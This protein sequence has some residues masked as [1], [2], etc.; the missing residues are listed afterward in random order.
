MS[1]TLHPKEKGQ[2]AEAIVMA[3]L[4]RRGITVLQPFGDN[5]RYDLVVDS[6]DDFHRI[7]VK[8]GRIDN[9]SIVFDIKSTGVNAHSTEHEPY[10]EDEIDFFAGYCFER[11]EVYIIPI[12]ETGSH[13]MSLRFEKADRNYPHINWVDDYT[14]STWIDTFRD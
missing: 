11:D 14:L 5:E 6:G 1:E 13:K 7:Q 12:Q 8:T 4:V 3:E 10:S 2:Q 9:G